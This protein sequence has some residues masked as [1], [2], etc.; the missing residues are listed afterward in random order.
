MAIATSFRA[1]NFRG[2]IEQPGGGKTTGNNERLHWHEIGNVDITTQQRYNRQMCWCNEGSNVWA[3][4]TRQFRKSSLVS[5]TGWRNWTSP[6]PATRVLQPMLK[7]CCNLA[8][9]FKISKGTETR[10]WPRWH[11]CWRECTLMESDAGFGSTSWIRSSTTWSSTMEQYE[12]I[13]LG[14]IDCQEY[15]HK[16]IAAI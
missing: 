7:S 13:S 10:D 2:Q 6:K 3:K 14:E 8:T 5:R 16:L 12:N 9:T 15:Q 11:C 1:V 4:T